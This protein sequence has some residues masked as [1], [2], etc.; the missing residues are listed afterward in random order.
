[1]TDKKPGIRIICSRSGELCRLCERFASEGYEVRLGPGTNDPGDE[2]I[3]VVG[4]LLSEQEK[5]ALRAVADSDSEGTPASKACMT[6]RALQGCLRRARWKLGCP[7][8]L[9]AV[10]QALRYGLIET[11]VNSTQEKGGKNGLL[12]S[13]GSSYHRG[14]LRGERR[15][16]G[17]PLA[18][19]ATAQAP[20]VALASEHV[21]QVHSVLRSAGI[22]P[23]EVTFTRAIPPQP[24]A[25]DIP[26]FTPTEILILRT[27]ADH[28]TIPVTAE[29]LNM[30]P[31]TVE[32][33]LANVRQ[34]ANV[35]TTIQTV[36]CVW[37]RGLIP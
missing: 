14:N 29:H 3:L 28:G 33:H 25:A 7:T 37:R 18:G 20:V 5:Q 30:N 2:C 32:V 1:M 36:A 6:P 12:N 15:M 19:K 8:T 31:R 10:V 21:Q 17:K 4:A 23:A 16:E 11:Y 35:T 24:P 13:G 27:I 26:T 34:K 9:Q 22:E